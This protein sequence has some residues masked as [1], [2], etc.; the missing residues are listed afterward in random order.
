MQA[1]TKPKVGS[2]K[3]LMKNDIRGN[4]HKREKKST[5]KQYQKWERNTPI[6]IAEIKRR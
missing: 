4:A 5:N 1:S 3:R 2:M 6:E